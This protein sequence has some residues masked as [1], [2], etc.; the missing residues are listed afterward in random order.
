MTW[1]LLRWWVRHQRLTLVVV[2]LAGLAA[3]VVVRGK[4][5]GDDATTDHMINVVSYLLVT[6]AAIWWFR[7]R[8]RRR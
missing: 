2:W 3:A 5:P 1:R 7:R 4:Y 6:G 8:E